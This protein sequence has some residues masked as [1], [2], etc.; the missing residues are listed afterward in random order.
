VPAQA[1]GCIR[2]T[3]TA[4]VHPP[5]YT[6]DGNSQLFDFLWDRYD[7]G[8]YRYGGTQGWDGPDKQ[9]WDGPD[10]KKSLVMPGAEAEVFLNGQWQPCRVQECEFIEPN[11]RLQENLRLKRPFKIW[12]YILETR[13]EYIYADEVFL[14]IRSR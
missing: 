10:N 1:D 14:R 8:G 4:T 12:R 7:A 2:L 13:G 3:T 11:R 9:G 6:G 5:P